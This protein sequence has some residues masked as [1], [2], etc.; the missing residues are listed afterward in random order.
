MS[1]VVPTQQANVAPSA[2]DRLLA[3]PPSNLWRDAALRFSKNKLA[4]AAMII[5]LLMVFTSVFA[6]VIA[7]NPNKSILS[8]TRL[9]PGQQSKITGQIYILGTDDVGRDL[10]KRI[11][12]GTRT[13]LLVGISVQAIALVVG[14]TLG[15]AGGFAGGWVDFVVMRIVE[16]FTAIPQLLFALFL[17]SIFGG[18]LVNV[19]LAIG[20]IGWVDIC[21]LVRAQL[22]SLREKEFIEAARAIGVPPFQIAL[23]HLLPNSLT[24]LIIAVTLGIPT[25]IFTE[26]GLSFLGLGINEPIASLGKMVGASSSYI[27]VYWHMGVFPTLMIALTMLSFSFVGDGLRDALDPR[28]KK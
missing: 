1:I 27:R 25:A 26:A 7:P 24:P 20:L 9:F 15:L 14:M 17:I 21:R 19:I 8:D 13:S 10:L 23:R 3:R 12:H 16:L 22:F 5:V 11:I 18:G 28:L 6:D 2:V 4:M